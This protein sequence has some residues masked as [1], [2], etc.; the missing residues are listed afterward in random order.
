MLMP[1]MN[2]ADADAMLMRDA[3]AMLSYAIIFAAA[4]L[5]SDI[6]SRY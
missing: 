4:M 3:D 1:L 5:F 2:I 6:F